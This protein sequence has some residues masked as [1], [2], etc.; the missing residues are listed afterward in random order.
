MGELLKDNRKMLKISSNSVGCGLGLSI[1]NAIVNNMGHGSKKGIT[2]QSN[3]S[4]G[5]VFSFTVSNSYQL[6]NDSVYMNSQTYVKVLNS[7]YYIE[8]QPSEYGSYRLSMS[9]YRS[10]FL[11]ES[12]RYE[13]VN[14]KRSNST[15]K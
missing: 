3:P 7:T 1:S 5:S 9:G 4:R 8:H 13:A 2:F 6:Y 15:R 11:L 14:N 12:E 10:N